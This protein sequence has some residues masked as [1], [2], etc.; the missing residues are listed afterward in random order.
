MII[1]C[2]KD[3]DPPQMPEILSYDDF[4]EFVQADLF[5]LSKYGISKATYIKKPYYSH[6]TFFGYGCEIHFLNDSIDTSV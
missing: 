1:V 5:R 6:V 3:S 2:D 4:K